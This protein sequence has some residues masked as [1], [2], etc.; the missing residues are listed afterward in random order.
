MPAPTT[1]PVAIHYIREALKS[2][3]PHGLT[4]RDLRILTGYAQTSINWWLRSKHLAP[5]V[6]KTWERP[7]TGNGRYRWRLKDAGAWLR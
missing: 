5:D 4:T 6:L 3:G 2:A 7:A 1:I